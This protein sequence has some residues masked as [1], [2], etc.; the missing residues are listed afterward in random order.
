MITTHNASM[1]V[2][3]LASPVN[4]G[5]NGGAGSSPAVVS[6]FWCVAGTSAASAANVC[7]ALHSA[8]PSVHDRIKRF[9]ICDSYSSFSRPA[10]RAA[11]A[12]GLAG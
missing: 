11:V 12:A 3:V 9:I 1:Y 10:L 2:C 8:I 5:S 6:D 4:G 7:A